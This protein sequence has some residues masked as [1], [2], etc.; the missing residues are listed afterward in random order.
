V[1][2]ESRYNN[3]DLNVFLSNFNTLGLGKLDEE[4]TSIIFSATYDYVTE[5]LIPQYEYYSNKLTNFR[6]YLVTPTKKDY[7][8]INDFII[9]NDIDNTDVIMLEFKNDN[10]NLLSMVMS[11][12]F[13][14]L[15]YLLVNKL[16]KKTIISDLDVSPFL[17]SLE[18]LDEYQSVN[19]ICYDSK[20]HNSSLRILSGGFSGYKLN[21]NNIYLMKMYCNIHD[22]ILSTYKIGNKHRNICIDQITLGD[23][24]FIEYIKFN[25]INR[26]YILS[27]NGNI[28][29]FYGTIAER[30]DELNKFIKE[31]L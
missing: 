13:Y 12:R 3:F 20:F 31:N 29:A 23:L 28:K 7:E 17:K 5:L 16:S 25:N 1:K 10:M 21:E 2:D 9:N 4:E 14:F 27:K 11:I 15:T 26:K 24:L 8:L 6:I 18:Y 19:L 22:T 30:R